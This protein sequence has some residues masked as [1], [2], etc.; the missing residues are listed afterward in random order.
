MGSMTRI[1]A[2]TPSVDPMTRQKVWDL[3]REETTEGNKLLGMAKAMREEADRVVDERG[4]MKHE[5]RLRRGVNGAPPAETV[6]ADHR[7]GGF[8]VTQDAKADWMYFSRRATMYSTEAAA[9]FAAAANWMAY[10]H[11]MDK[12]SS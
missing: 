4:E 12:L 3:W 8:K 6:I 11:E 10:Y 1:Q 5:Y 7:L 9:H 2:I